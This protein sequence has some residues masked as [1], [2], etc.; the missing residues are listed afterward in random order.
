M[1]SCACGV[2]LRES[3]PVCRRDQVVIPDPEPMRDP[4]LT[5]D[6]REFTPSHLNAQLS[7]AVRYTAHLF[8]A[9]TQ[10]KSPMS[11][12][13]LGQTATE[14]QPLLPRR[15]ARRPTT[16]TRQDRSPPPRVIITSHTSASIRGRSRRASRGRP[17]KSA[18][19]PEPKDHLK[20]AKEALHGQKPTHSWQARRGQSDKPL[21]RHAPGFGSVSSEQIDSNTFDT[22]SAGDH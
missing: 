8:T 20:H 12:C 1:V 7:S 4:T 22:V 17:C 15:D 3:A 13:H 19:S 21:E 2:Q 5:P 18:R 11:G 10:F 14:I 16:K 9:L 6:Q